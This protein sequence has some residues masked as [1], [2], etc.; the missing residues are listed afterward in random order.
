MPLDF[1]AVA[2]TSMRLE[3]RMRGAA[4]SHNAAR[5]AR[6][7]RALAFVGSGLHCALEAYADQT[8]MR[9]VK[10]L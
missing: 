5:G 4:I 9:S 3:A 6:K 1:A 10:P 2:V 8:A 7:A